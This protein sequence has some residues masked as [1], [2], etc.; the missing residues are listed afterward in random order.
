MLKFTFELGS[1]LPI[2]IGKGDAVNE[3][4][5]YLGCKEKYPFFTRK[6]RLSSKKFMLDNCSL[7]SKSVLITGMLV[8]DRLT[9]LELLEAQTLSV[10]RFEFQVALSISVLL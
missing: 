4:S 7:L 8:E 6:P 3:E 9:P 2:R 1:V 5:V 10:D